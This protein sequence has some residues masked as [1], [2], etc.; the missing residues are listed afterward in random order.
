MSKQISRGAILALALAAARFGY[1]ATINIQIQAYPGEAVADGRSSIAVTL[2]VR[3]SDGSNVPDGTQVV[4]ST[5][6]GNFRESI[7]RTT[8]GIAR[9]ILVSGNIPGTAKITAATLQNQSNPTLMEV[10]FVSDR[11]KLSSSNDFVE[12]SSTGSL[13]FTYAKRITT[14]SA[15]NRGIKFQFKD[16]MIQAED[17]QYLYDAQIVRAR[18]ATYKLG[19][20]EF[21]FSDLFLDLRTLKGFG[22]TEIDNLAVDRIRYNGGLFFFEHLNPISEKY[23]LAKLAKRTA[24][25]AIGRTGISLPTEA[26]RP[27]IFDYVKIREGIVPTTDKE[28]AGEKQR[29]FDTVRITAKRM[30]VVSR[31]EIQFQRATFYVGESKIFS[32][33]LYRMDTQGLQS[34]FPTDQYISF[35]NNQFGMNIPY[36]LSLEKNQSQAIRFSTGQTFGRGYSTNR[37]VFFDLEQSWNKPS[38][39]GKFTVAGIGR[40]DYNLGLR[41][42]SKIDEN[43]TASFAID[44]PQAKSLI[45]SAAISKYQPGLQ[46]SLSGTFI[47]GLNGVTTSD[48]QDYY[49]VMEKDPIK[50]GKMPWNMYYGLNATYSQSTTS[51]G[52]GAGARLR[53]ISNQFNTDRSGGSL[54]AGLTF[55]QFAGANIP[56]PFAT[57]ATVT[58]SK[59]FGQKFNTMLTYDYAKDG[60]T[61]QFN[62]EDNRFFTSLFATQSIGQDKISL[63]ADTSYRIAN[64]WRIGYQ[65]T[66]NNYGGSSFVDYNI[67]LGYRVGTDRPEFGLLYS[68]QTQRIGFVLLGLSRN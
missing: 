58:Y 24:V 42:F 17:L 61:E 32:Q 59:P 2:F 67:V 34:Q 64:L 54:S 3:N 49:L 39:D 6:L 52:S 28:V 46:T 65:Y 4:L 36:Y 7:V 10:E 13:E 33:Q 16:R 27:E 47:R 1:S 48:R 62:F 19:D 68:Q 57:T 51:S 31:R 15:P 66:L 21:T 44:S 22:I 55:S 37:G 45:S 40:D 35:N 12:L 50:L 8:S 11:S 30:T 56:T 63:F 20:K 53:L 26:V 9:T 43:T 5:T 23:E 18:R 41:Q 29:D 60:I 14:A 25:V 38:G